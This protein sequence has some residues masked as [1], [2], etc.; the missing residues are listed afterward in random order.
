MSIYRAPSVKPREGTRNPHAFPISI[1][2]H[3]FEMKA[4]NAA[5]HPRGTIRAAEV[6]HR[7]RNASPL[8]PQNLHTAPTTLRVGP[9]PPARVR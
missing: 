8:G 3:V 2:A 4:A 1:P 5:V 7:H 6:S 9:A